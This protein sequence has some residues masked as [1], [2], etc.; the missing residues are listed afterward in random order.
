M[1]PIIE[2]MSLKETPYLRPSIA[3]AFLVRV[4]VDRATFVRFTEKLVAGIPF[5]R[6]IHA[7]GE[8]ILYRASSSC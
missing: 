5:T 8:N 1:A 6:A 3:L 7:R 2:L 4:R